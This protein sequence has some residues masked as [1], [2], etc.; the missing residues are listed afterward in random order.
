MGRRGR[1]EVVA[2]DRDLVTDGQVV[3]P[4]NHP[5]G[6]TLDQGRRVGQLLCQGVGGVGAAIAG[7]TGPGKPHIGQRAEAVREPFDG[8]SQVRGT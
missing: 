4:G 3:Q 2:G 1:D 8:G 7:A 6:T 5:A